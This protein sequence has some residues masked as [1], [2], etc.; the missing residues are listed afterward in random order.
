[1]GGSGRGFFSN[2]TP[3]ELRERIRAEEEK[4][5]NQEF[6]NKVAGALGDLL[7]DANKRDSGEIQKALSEVRTCLAAEIEGDFEPMF[8]G[9]V[10]KHT[11]VDGISDVDALMILRDETLGEK[12]PQEVL[13]YFEDRLRSQLSDWEISPHGKLAVTLRRDDLE[14]QVL[15]AIHRAGGLSIPAAEG[16]EWSRIDPEKFQRRLTRA[17]RDLGGKL[18]PVIK[19]AKV[20]NG[21]FPDASRLTG[22]HIESLAI[23]SFRDYTGAVNSKAMLK[24][25]F[26]RARS[27]VLAPIRDSTGQSVHVDEY[28]GS[29]N[30]P[31]RR[32]AAAALDRVYRQMRNADALGSVDA[33]VKLFGDK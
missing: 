27:I 25:F 10:R 11:Y 12:S 31:D 29:S 16:N 14:L 22:Y 20:I 2:T 24:H 28:M 1:M 5:A 17:N 33:W 8:G 6:E 9:S 4:T 19:L 32:I 30:S 26:D 13:A 23:Q 21:S 7:S 3:E 18:I 15:P